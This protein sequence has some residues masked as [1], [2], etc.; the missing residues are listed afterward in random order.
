VGEPWWWVPD[1]NGKACIHDAAAE[2]LYT[3]ETGLPVPV[4]ITDLRAALT[5]EQLAYVA[6]CGGLL[7]RSTLALRDAVRDEAADAITHLLFY[8]PQV[9]DRAPAF[10]ALNLPVE[11]AWPA[12]DVL[13]LEDYDFVIRDDAGAQ[14]R[15]V[16][17]VDAK[18]GYPVTAQHY[19]SGFATR[20]RDLALWRAILDA[21][22]RA[23]ARGVAQRILWAL[24]QVLRD[25][26]T[27]FATGGD[28]DSFHDVEFPLALGL[29][30]RIAP[31]FQ[32]QVVTTT[33]G[34]ERR[35]S[36]W[37]QARLRFDAGLGVRSE[38]DMA[39]LLAFF[40]ARRGQ[41]VA[42]RL[43]DPSD[44]SSAG[45]TGA[46]LPNDQTL[47]VGDG[48][49][50]RFAL[51]KAYGGDGPARRITRPVA[52]TV[53]TAVGGVEL[54]SGWTLAPKGELWFDAP[55]A[56][57]AAVTAGFR[58]DVPVRFGSD[59]ME[60]SLPALAAGEAPDVPLVEVR[61]A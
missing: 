42:F 24:P 20:P 49:R 1:A 41:A 58:F 47:G 19:L 48:V 46:P 11:W 60:I 52:G 6:W 25:G 12:F 27:C 9:L 39:A 26:F 2:A 57:G 54:S 61:E 40:R 43:R 55:P 59:T 10:E 45:M 13:Q 30:A 37:S 34:H 7:G 15:A 31:G 14:T 17:T 18:L 38:A 50:T 5:P 44:N 29:E 3:V 33:S 35:N 22:A 56:I 51:V 4:R 36:L 53:R 16:A 21:D 32:T 8:A 23:A 28:M